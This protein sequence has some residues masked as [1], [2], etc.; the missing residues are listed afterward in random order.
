MREVNGVCFNEARNFIN[1]AFA[2]SEKRGADWN[3]KQITGVSMSKLLSDIADEAVGLLNE[4]NLNC[5][6][7][8]LPDDFDEWK[9][10]VNAFL[11]DVNA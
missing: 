2:D 7:D 1:E 11:E 8:W 5:D 9:D 6:G 4:F 10:R 3:L